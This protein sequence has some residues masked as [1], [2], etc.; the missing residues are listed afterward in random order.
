MLFGRY[1]L[2][3]VKLLLHCVLYLLLQSMAGVYYKRVGAFGNTPEMRANGL[4]QLSGING[5]W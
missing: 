2:V 1:S 5:R 4:E 3:R